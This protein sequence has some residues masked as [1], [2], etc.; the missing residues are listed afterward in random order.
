MTTLSHPNMIWWEV[1]VKAA[2]LCPTLCNLMD[3]TV[4]GILQARILKWVPFP[5]SGDL[6]NPGIKPRSPTLQ[7]DSLPGEPQAK[8]PKIALCHILWK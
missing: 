6:H 1:K 8:P 7:T 5:F 2:Q 4:N 3:Y